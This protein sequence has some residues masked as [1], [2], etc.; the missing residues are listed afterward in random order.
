[1]PHS[2]GPNIIVDGRSLRTGAGTYESTVHRELTLLLAFQTGRAVI[3]EIWSKHRHLRVVPRHNRRDPV[4]ADAQAT[5][6]RAA[7]A[8]FQPLRDAWDGHRL[9]DGG[10]GTGTGSD[11]R[12]HYSPSVFT[13]EDAFEWDGTARSAWFNMTGTFPADPGQDPAEI[14]LHELVHA[15]RMMAGRMDYVALGHRFDTREE[16]FAILVTNMYS[17]ERGPFRPLRADHSRG[18][19]ADPQTWRDNPE[20]Q[21]LIRN[22]CASSPAL[23]NRLMRLKLPFNPFAGAYEHNPD[24]NE[25]G[26]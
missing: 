11:A 17:S 14:L 26:G 12:I 16:F 4:N 19:L 22:L 1:M 23:A 20:L 15:L 25:L 9:P 18:N 24:L 21:T 8:P 2:F 7:N 5:N 6:D 13:D 10:H 3:E